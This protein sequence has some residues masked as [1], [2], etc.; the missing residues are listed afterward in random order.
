MTNLVQIRYLRSPC[1]YL[2]LVFF[3]FD[4]PS[5]LRVVH[6]RKKNSFSQKMDPTIFIKFCGFIVHSNSNNMALS[7]FPGKILVTRKIFL[8]FYPSPNVAPKPTDQSCSN[9]IFRILLQ[10]SP[11]SPFHFRPS[12]NIKGILMLRVVHIRNKKRTDWQ[13]WNFTNTINCFF[14][15]VIKSAGE[16][17]KKVLLMSHLKSNAN[18]NKSLSN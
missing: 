5:K 17:A 15:Y 8:N 1:K 2:Q 4:L 14:C 6:I 13:T 9:S 16:I 3:I 11:A 18:R 10:L 7:A 12:L